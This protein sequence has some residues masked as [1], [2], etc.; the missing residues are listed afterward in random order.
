MSR[1]ASDGKHDWI[2]AFGAALGV[3]ALFTFPYL[4]SRV[5]MSGPPQVVQTAV[6]RPV[7][8]ALAGALVFRDPATQSRELMG[9]YHKRSATHTERPYRTAAA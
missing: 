3:C 2:Y 8:T 4:L 7:V 1:R 5:D 9:Y 6:E